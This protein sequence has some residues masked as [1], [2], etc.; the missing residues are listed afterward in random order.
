MW[1]PEKETDVRLGLS[2]I[3]LE[4]EG[5]RK[6]FGMVV[7][8]RRVRFKD[9]QESLH[10]DREEAR[11]QLKSLKDA[12]LIEERGAPFEDFHLYYVTAEGLEAARE[13]RRRSISLD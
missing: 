1:H 2:P 8:Q 4:D 5:T 13:L 9:L 3:T 7:D 10:L 6:V 11:R 12:H